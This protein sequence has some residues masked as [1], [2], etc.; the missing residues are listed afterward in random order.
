MKL[1]F[2]SDRKKKTQVLSKI[3]FR[4]YSI[5][6]FIESDTRYKGEN[7]YQ[8]VPAKYKIGTYKQECQR[9]RD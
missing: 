7:W 5:Y 8:K 1:L 9:N 2:S 3:L 6:L 4:S